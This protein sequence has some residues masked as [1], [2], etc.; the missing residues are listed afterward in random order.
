MK[1]FLLVL[2]TLST[3]RGLQAQVLVDSLPLFI[4]KRGIYTSYTS[5]RNNL[6]NRYDSFRIISR[7]KGDI[8]LRGGGPFEFELDSADKYEFHA[9]RKALVGISDGKQFYISD[10]YTSGKW[11]G[12]SKCYLQGPY[13]LSF[14]GF[15]I[16]QYD[17]GI[18]PRFALLSSG[19]VIDIRTREHVLL[20]EEFLKVFLKKYP[21]LDEKYRNSDLMKY[22]I[23]ILEIVNLKEAI[24]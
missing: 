14:G 20:D 24:K 17:G 15:N 18:V 22:A 13:V 6:P 21:E 11:M 4:V 2:L 16:D 1:S 3:L 23:E 12:I 8:F 19:F 7:A 10:K 9:L 5:L